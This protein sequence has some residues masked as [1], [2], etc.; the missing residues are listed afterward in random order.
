MCVC[1]YVNGAVFVLVCRDANGD[2]ALD[3]AVGASYHDEQRGAVY[4]MFL[5]S[6]G[7]VLSFQKISATSGD[8]TGILDDAD[9]F[10]FSVAALGYGVAC[11]CH[12][13]HTVTYI[14]VY[15]IMVK[16]DRKTRDTGRTHDVC[17]CVCV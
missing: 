8:F 4:V 16:S 9:G 2:G 6:N 11:A 5:D 15:I 1:M 17:V 12:D 14:V 3:L 7:M 13:I 10:G